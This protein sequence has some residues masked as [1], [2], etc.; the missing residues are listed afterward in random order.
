MAVVYF[1]ESKAEKC[2]P[3]LH[4]YLCKYCGCSNYQKA[5]LNAVSKDSPFS[6]ISSFERH[7]A[8]SLSSIKTPAKINQL[9]EGDISRVVG[10]ME[11]LYL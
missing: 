11:G 9:A 6:Y 1:P 3:Y 5:M 7:L 4:A 2:P 8:F 10:V